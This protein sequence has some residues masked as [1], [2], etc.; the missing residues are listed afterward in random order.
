MTL[1]S[2]SDQFH[3]DPFQVDDFHVVI[4]PGLHNSGPGHWQTLWQQADPRFVRV[5]QNNWDYP[6]LDEWVSRLDRLRAEDSRP[7]LLVAH[8]FGCLTAA[9]SAARNPDRLAGMLLVAPAHPDRFGVAAALPVHRLPC[10]SVLVSS[11]NDP[12]MP[13]DT[14]AQYAR[15]WGSELV[16][17]GPL[18]H[19]NADSGLGAWPDGQRLL[20]QLVQRARADLMETV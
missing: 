7:A 16:E 3:V 14:A 9:C 12:W 2:F 6:R 11:A 1:Q 17:G 4:V 15:R 18:G 19:I 8:S 5:Q 20:R 10:R 13:A